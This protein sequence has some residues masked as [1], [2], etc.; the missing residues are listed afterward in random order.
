MCY[1]QCGILMR[2]FGVSISRPSQSYTEKPC[3]MH[4]NHTKLLNTYPPQPLSSHNTSIPGKTTPAS[5]NSVK[6]SSN[7]QTSKPSPARHITGSLG[8]TISSSNTIEQWPSI[9]KQGGP[10][11]QIYLRQ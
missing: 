11:R 7:T 10:M 1:W 5:P 2:P 4:R 8:L 9:K 3:N 6:R